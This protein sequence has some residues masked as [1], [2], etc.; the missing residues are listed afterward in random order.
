MRFIFSPQC[1]HAQ[2]LNCFWLSATPGT[3]ALQAPL[4]RRF[5]RQEYWSG[6]PCLPPGD[7]PNPGIE[8]RSP[9]LQVD[10]L[11]SEL[12]GKRKNT[13]VGS[14]SLLQGTFPTQELNWGL[15]HCSR[16]LHQL[17]YQGSPK[18]SEI[19][20]GKQ[21]LGYLTLFIFF[22]STPYFKIMV[23]SLH[24]WGQLRAKWDLWVWAAFTH[25]SR[26]LMPPS[27]T[28]DPLPPPSPQ[29][30]NTEDRTMSHCQISPW[31]VKG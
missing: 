8:P 15:L 24:C 10:S 4:C 2:L 14:L 29:K 1:V 18:G 13:G 23:P 28:P 27:I 6:L 9:A 5:S 16:F 17:N 31:E 26:M 25:L 3:A 20:R 12:R 11:P 22:P 7:L 21:Y 19:E 30:S